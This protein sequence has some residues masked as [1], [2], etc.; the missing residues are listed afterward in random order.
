MIHR[1]QDDRWLRVTPC[2]TAASFMTID[3]EIAADTAGS[4]KV[5]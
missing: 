4:G 1:A 3:A 2:V 5:A